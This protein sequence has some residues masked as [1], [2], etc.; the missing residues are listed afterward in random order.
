MEAYLL[1]TLTSTGWRRGGTTY[2]TLDSALTEGRRLIRRKLARSV[3]VLPVAVDVNAVAE[4]PE[5]VK[6]ALRLKGEDVPE[7]RKQPAKPQPD[8]AAEF[9]DRLKGGRADD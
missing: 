7:S 6:F 5:Y 4:I 2:W 3:R 8:P 1:E 9:A